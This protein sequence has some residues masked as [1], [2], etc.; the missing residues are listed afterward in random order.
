M[1]TSHLTAVATKAAKALPYDRQYSVC[2]LLLSQPA[3]GLAMPMGMSMVASQ[4]KSSKYHGVSLDKN[5]RRWRAYDPV[6]LLLYRAM[7]VE[8]PTAALRCCAAARTL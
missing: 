7:S 4:Q 2:F 8:R 5:S 1:S 6:D 3:V